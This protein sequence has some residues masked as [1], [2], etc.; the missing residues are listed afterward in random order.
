MAV[1]SAQV[2]VGTTATE[3][4]AADTDTRLGQT[5]IVKNASAATAVFLGGSGVTT[6][7]GLSLAAAATVTVE[8]GQG[9]EL[10]GIVA[11]ATETVHVLR[12]GT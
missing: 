6:S 12:T 8:L 3:L 10:Y 5:L 1:T 7:T 9:E 11:A 2:S 4:S